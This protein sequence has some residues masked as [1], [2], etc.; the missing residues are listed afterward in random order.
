LVFELESGIITIQ[1]MPRYP[2][3]CFCPYC[4][5]SRTFLSQE[6]DGGWRG[7]QYGANN[8]FTVVLADEFQNSICLSYVNMTLFY[9]PGN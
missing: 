5:I 1:T 3:G 8:T 4:T 2:E 7:Y 9:S 6:Y